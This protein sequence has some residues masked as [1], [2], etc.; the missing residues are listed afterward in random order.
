MRLIQG[1]GL[2]SSQAASLGAQAA[3]GSEIAAGAMVQRS[4]LTIGNFDG[5]HLGH[6]ALIRELV[7]VARAQQVP[8]VVMTFDPHPVKV[9]YPDRGLK[10]IFSFEDQ[11]HVL[12]SMGVDT[13]VVEAFSRE[14]SQLSPEHYLQDWIYKPFHPH[15]IVVGHDF[16]FGANRQGTIEFLEKRGREL[17]FRVVTV[18]PVK[19]RVHGQEVI[20]SSTRVRESLALGDVAQ[21]AGFLG[22][23]FYLEG[24]VERGAG[25]GR[26]IGVP[27]ANLS[28]TAELVPAQ[29]VYSTIA[30]VRGRR[31]KAVT[32]I[33]FNPTFAAQRSPTL[34]PVFHIETHL[35]DVAQDLYGEILKIEFVQRL[36][37]ERKFSGVDELV[38]QIHRDIE[39]ARSHLAA[40]EG[41]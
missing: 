32:N 12:S 37:E 9:L 30:T 16:S 20:I 39:A 15:T 19:T 25:R 26:T 22:R 31:H 14:F 4:A 7:A 17:S 23:R 13:L 27:T 10:R 8:A 5:M 6:Q 21:V 35:L 29:G 40:S 36:R 41:L 18:A 28:S 3:E 24:L 1:L 38:S 33:G 11:A 2:R 34:A